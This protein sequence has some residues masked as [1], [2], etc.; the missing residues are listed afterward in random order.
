[1]P[2]KRELL[3]SLRASAA[4][5]AKFAVEDPDGGG[6]PEDTHPGRGQL[7]FG[8]GLVVDH[9]LRGAPILG[10]EQFQGL[11]NQS[12]GSD[13]DQ[14]IRTLA[15]G[16]LAGVAEYGGGEGDE[17][18]R[19]SRPWLVGLGGSVLAFPAHANSRAAVST[20]TAAAEIPAGARE[21]RARVRN[22]ENAGGYTRHGEVSVG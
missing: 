19:R 1:M 9:E 18:G 6:L 7:L 14:L 21:F 11:G 3:W 17:Y 16:H 5:L 22:P 10:C 8:L 4:A 13:Q 15:R 2:A 20:A 12:L